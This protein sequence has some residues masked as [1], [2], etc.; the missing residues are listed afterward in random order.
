[1]FELVDVDEARNMLS[2]DQIASFYSSVGLDEIIVL[3]MHNNQD[4]WFVRLKR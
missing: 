2:E 3:L 4:A 1:L